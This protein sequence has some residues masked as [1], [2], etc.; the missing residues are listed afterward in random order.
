MSAKNFFY[1]AAYF[2]YLFFEKRTGFFFER[3][4]FKKRTGYFLDVKNPKSFNQ[5]ICCMKLFDK[6]PLLPVVVDKYEVR[7]YVSKKLGEHEANKV[8][9]DLIA[10][11]ESPEEL[12]FKSLPQQFVIKSTHGSGTTKVIRDKDKILRDE[13]VSLCQEWLSKPY[14]LFKHEWA[15]QKVKR[16]IVVE[17]L[18]LEEGEIP[19]DYKF[20]MFKGHCEMIQ[21][22][23]GDF[24]RPETRTL[25]LY[26]PDWEPINVEWEYPPS[27]TN[28]KP[29]NLP[30]MLRIA[31]KLSEDFKYVRVDL[32]SVG[33]KVK[34]GEITCYPTS[35]SAHVNPVEFDFDLGNKLPF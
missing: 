23:K 22:N 11:E 8:L 15:Y 17:E 20:H 25:T 35:G 30:K 5:K 31:E 29:E 7:K 24:W 21:V 6:N 19:K 12:D 2:F 18:L 32:Y 33:E 28:C 10:V 34:F 1:N 26:T 4:R 3:K 27:F 9:I 13:L 14:G 16:K